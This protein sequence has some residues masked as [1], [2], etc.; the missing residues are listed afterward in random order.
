MHEYTTVR[1]P[2]PGNDHFNVYIRELSGKT[3]RMVPEIAGEEI[4]IRREGLEPGYY[5]IEFLGPRHYQGK[6]IVR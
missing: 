3:V 2:N 4:T 5:I 1:F 6:L